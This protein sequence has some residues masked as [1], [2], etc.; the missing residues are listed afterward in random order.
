MQLIVYYSLINKNYR[1]YYGQDGHT[2]SKF[3]TKKCR[4]NY[5][6]H[7]QIGL[8]IDHSLLEEN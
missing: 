6:R 1:N 3:V 2:N 7:F 8:F 5:S 4:F